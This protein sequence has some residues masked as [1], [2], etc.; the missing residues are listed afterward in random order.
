MAKLLLAGFTQ[1]RVDEYTDDS[2]VA[3][4]DPQELDNITA[5]MERVGLKIRVEG[6]IGDFLGV[7]I[8]KLPNATIE[9]TQPQLIEQVLTDLRLHRDNT[10]RKQTLAPSSQ[11][12]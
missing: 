9:M 6:D 4:P 7:N 11:I 5:D 2:I 10:A 3:G 8:K 12:L 1:S